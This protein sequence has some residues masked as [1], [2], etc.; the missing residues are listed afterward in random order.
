M[1]RYGRSGWIESRWRDQ[2]YPE[3]AKTNIWH[4]CI[5]RGYVNMLKSCVQCGYSL[6][7]LPGNHAC[8][9]CGL[10]F[11]ERSQVWRK[12]PGIVVFAAMFGFLGSIGAWIQLPGVPPENSI[13]AWNRSFR[14]FCGHPRLTLPASGLHS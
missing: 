5:V 4:W 13:R 8:P 9:E 7:G 3:A 6:K 11:D 12:S 10:R 14:H 2:L 1:T